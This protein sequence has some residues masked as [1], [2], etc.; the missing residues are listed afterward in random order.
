M[1]STV[2]SPS[3]PLGRETPPPWSFDRLCAATVWRPFLHVARRK[4]SRGGTPHLIFWLAVRCNGAEAIPPCSPA[5]KRLKGE[6]TPPPWS[7]EWLLGPA[8]IIYCINSIYKG[9]INNTSYSLN[10][11]FWMKRKNSLYIARHPEIKWP[12]KNKYRSLKAKTFIMK[13]DHCAYSILSFNKIPRNFSWYEHI[14]RW[15][16]KTIYTRAIS[17]RPTIA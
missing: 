11:N 1:P 7:F 10:R 12:I 17:Q 2:S 14:F 13:L 16:N 9:K 3:S 8:F 5:R 4:R 6:V 15:L